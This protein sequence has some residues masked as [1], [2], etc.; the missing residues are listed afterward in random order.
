MSGIFDCR[1]TV[2][3][4]PLCVLGW[5]PC[6][7]ADAPRPAWNELSGKQWANTWFG[8]GATATFMGGYAGFVFSPQ[9]DLWNN[10][11]V[12]R[13]GAILGAY[14]YN[15]AA[16]FNN[17]KVTTGSGEALVGYRWAIDS[18][19]TR[20]FT[21]YVGGNLEGHDQPDPAALLRGTRFGVK[22]MVELIGPVAERLNFYGQASYSTAFDTYFAIG[23]LQYRFTDKIEFGPE[24]IALGDVAIDEMRAGAALTFATSFGNVILSGGYL[25]PTRNTGGIVKEGFY[26]NVHLTYVPR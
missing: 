11:V 2:L 12:L 16:P 22:G 13:G 23:R 20:W 21:A 19:Q 4:L 10:G 18:S 9:R 3:A 17:E 15:G 26:G 14:D 7:A 24:V 1:Q 25:W 8:F 6:S 5:L